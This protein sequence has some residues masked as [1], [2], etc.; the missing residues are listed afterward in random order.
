MSGHA[1]LAASASHRWLNCPP[2]AALAATFPN[3][4]SVYADEGSLAHKIAYLKLDLALLHAGSRTYDHDMGECISNSLYSGE[5]GEYVDQYVTAIIERYNELRT[6][7]KD[8]LILLEQRLDFSEWVPDGFGTGDV[9]FIADELIE[10]IDLK[11]GK[12]V[13]VSAVDNPQTRLY[14]LGAIA[15]FGMLYDIQQVQMTIYQPRLDSVSHETMPVDEL[16]KWGDEYVRPIAA[17]A[18]EGQGEYHAGE[19]CRFCPAKATCWA[20]AE[21]NMELAAFDFNRPP[22]LSHDEIPCILDQLDEFLKWAHDVRTYALIQ[23]E[24]HGVKWP[25]WKLVRGRSN[26]TY[27]DKE[28]VYDKLIDAG[29]KKEKITET[30]LLGIT[31]MEKAL[32]KKKMQNLIGDLIIKPPGKPCLVPESDP[33][34]EIGTEEAKVEFEPLK[35]ENPE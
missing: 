14:G 5:M 18:R 15:G 12:G 13:P 25:G 35:E 30:E 28:A 10:V 22:L 7:C 9:V 24:L 16:V 29:Y 21:K 8:T 20:R 31:L 33:R 11:Y 2:S 32:G 23:A 4:S 6:D 34:P 19:H 1:Y 26:R 27:A 3:E 17:L